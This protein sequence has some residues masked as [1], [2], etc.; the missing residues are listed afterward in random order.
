METCEFF[1]GVSVQVSAEVSVK[2]FLF[3]HDAFELFRNTWCACTFY[4]A[5][6]KAIFEAP[7]NS[8]GK[9]IIVHN[10][11]LFYKKLFLNFKPTFK[12]P[13]MNLCTLNH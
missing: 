10:F 1:N 12:S 9:K 4:S 5:F 6:K 2:V 3:S 11:I 13:T 8:L 7:T